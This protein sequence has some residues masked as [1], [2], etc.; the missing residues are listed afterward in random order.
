MSLVAITSVIRFS[1]SL[2]GVEQRDRVPESVVALCAGNP[3]NTMLQLLAKDLPQWLRHAE[4]AELATAQ[5]LVAE[6]MRLWVDS[7]QSGRGDAIILPP[8]FKVVNANRSTFAGESKEVK[9][10][11]ALRCSKWDERTMGK[12]AAGQPGQ[13]A[14]TAAID[15]I[16]LDGGR[17]PP[18]MACCGHTRTASQRVHSCGVRY[19]RRHVGQTN[20]LQRSRCMVL[21]RYAH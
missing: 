15:S 3:E 17:A 8:D 7:N 14:D 4:S 1:T 18:G 20:K 9:A 10:F 11:L 16:L 12:M 6:H 19:A 21:R 2:S 13:R 5:K